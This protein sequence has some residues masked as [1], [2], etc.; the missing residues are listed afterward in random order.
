MF[1]N[2]IDY[3]TRM[4]AMLETPTEIELAYQ[5]CEDVFVQY[6]LDRYL[7][8]LNDYGLSVI[9]NYLNVRT[10][11][12]LN[13][14]EFERAWQ[15]ILLFE[16]YASGRLIPINMEGIHRDLKAVLMARQGRLAEACDVL[17]EALDL[18]CTSDVRQR[19]LYTLGSIETSMTGPEYK[20][21]TLCEALGE[22]EQEGNEDHI[23]MCY[24]ELSRM[25]AYLGQGATGLSLLQKAEQYYLIHHKEHEL[26]GT[27]MYMAMSYMAMYNT[28]KYTNQLG[29]ENM[30]RF[31]QQAKAYIG[32]ID[33]DKLLLE[34][35]RAFYYRT[36]GLI[37][38][39]IASIE[40]ALAFYQRVNA[41]QDIKDCE[42]YIKTIRNAQAQQKL[43]S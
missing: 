36:Y 32:M 16:R 34:S 31:I 2:E 12:F 29:E 28:P 35:D 23:A 17:R 1:I 40:K 25:F 21:N 15:P 3:K 4:M 38:V 18:G 20:I 22:A 30:E 13:R 42:G 37:Y 7:L 27:R 41:Y 24:R 9:L 43:Q 19:L 10:S 11:I 39:D 6:G 8:T 14:N 33:V 26:M 5:L